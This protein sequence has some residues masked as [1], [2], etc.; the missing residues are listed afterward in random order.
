MAEIN[1]L[2]ENLNLNFTAFGAKT[3]GIPSMSIGLNN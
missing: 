3:E 1:L 2:D